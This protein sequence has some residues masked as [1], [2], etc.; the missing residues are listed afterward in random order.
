MKTTFT[1]LRLHRLALGCLLGLLATASAVNSAHASDEV[2]NLRCEYLVNPLGIDALKPRLSWKINSDHRGE[3]QTAYQIIVASS[4]QKLA[5][6]DGDLW[7]SGKV[8]SDQ[9]N[10]IEYAGRTLVSRQ[11]CFWKVKTWGS[12]AASSAESKP[13]SWS[14]GQLNPEDWRAQWISDPVLADPANRPLTP[15]RCY[16]SELVS[17]PDAVKWIV[18]DLGASKRMEAVDVLPARPNG[19]GK[20]F[21]TVMFPERFKIEVADAADFQGSRTVVD[22][23]KA[24]LPS[25]REN[26]CQ[27]KFNPVTGRFVRLTVTRLAR[28]DGRDYGLALGGFR[29]LVGAN[30]ISTQAKVTCSDSLETDQWSH[31][32]LV[33]EKA[34][35]GIAKDSPALAV[36]MP[37]VPAKRLVSR[38]PLLRRD[39]ALDG[40][41]RRAVLSISAR[42]FYEVRINGQKVGQEYLAPGYT[43]SHSRLQYQSHDVTGL[44]RRGPNAIGALLG[45]GWYAG[46]MNLG[47]NRCFDGYFPQLLAQLDM[48]LSNGKKVTIAS[49]GAW[50]STLAGAVRSSDLLDGEACDYR[51][52]LPGWDQP[53]FDDRAWGKVWSQPRDSTPL[54]WQRAQPVRAI[55]VMHPVAVK[56]PKPGVYVFDMGQE[57]TGWCRLAVDGPAG[58][59]VVLRHAEMVTADGS[60]N[61]GNLWGTAQQDDYILDGKGPRTLE[62][63]FTYHGF[64]YV[65]VSGLPRPPTV[66]TL[67]VVNLR[68]ALPDVGRFECSNPLFNQL[69]NATRWT[70]WNML[71]DVPT[72]CAGRSERVA[73]MGD[74]RPCVQTACFN[75][76]AAAFFAKYSV[77]LRDAQKPDGRYTDIVPHA[78]LRGTE[79]A[80]GS[81]GWAD[82][83][84]SLPWEHWVN[85]ADRR[86]L[87]DHYASAKQWVDFVHSRNPNLLWKNALGQ[88]WGDWLS[89]GPATPKDLG[90]TAFF[91]NSADLVSRMALALGRHDEAETYRTLF[92]GI[93]QAF[94]RQ[95]VLSDGSI[96][97]VN[98]K[99]NA[100]GSYALALRFGLLDEP[101]RS[102]AAAKLAELVVANKYHPTTGFWSSIELLLALSDNG[103]H[104]EAARM[105]AQRDK[106][107]WGYMVDK[108]T[109]FWEAFDAI[110]K[111]LSLNHWTHSAVGEW[112]W[113]HVAGLN[114]DEGAPGYR[115]F[116]IR[117]RPSAEVSWCNS[118]YDSIRGKIVSNWVIEGGKMTME[119]T[120][121]AN[122]TATVYI[123]TPDSAGVTEAGQPAAKAHGIQFLR[124]E[125]GAAGYAVGSGN[126]RFQSHFPV[127]QK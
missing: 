4:P 109:T 62:P 66:E 105:L 60:I 56:E 99:N 108:S 27:F 30:A 15:I 45:Y 7:D 23:T 73:W 29:V 69:M 81:P 92:N 51:L 71:F 121:P 17:R 87:E 55:Q 78:H 117:P 88:N 43:D 24:D 96:G 97:A 111:N 52:D 103:H 57:M 67:E 18:L 127:F 114:P 70:Q 11:R 77:D 6:N 83:G 47:E 31:R 95:W 75:M 119:V 16:R 123:P 36:E 40:D 37:G 64:R 120:I 98:A 10:Q 2:A 125:N 110:H 38:V 21:R 82:A 41:I 100:Q 46:H 102:K 5:K 126:Y 107:S 34:D 49:D 112:L 90:A 74:I 65:E 115:S 48:E 42:G 72:G 39:F 122:T 89:A 118:S 1:P 8:P 76:D 79:V 113:R 53:G 3:V 94:V 35:V 68:S 101:L 44:L 104:A 124:M 58:S 12:D 25:P 91:A 33:A 28:W 80:V 26:R 54:V 85:Y 32:F 59:H 9:Q 106:P 14:M 84:V 86:A 93:R 20:D 13:A 116:T 50:R 22:Q 19:Q 61:M 63:H